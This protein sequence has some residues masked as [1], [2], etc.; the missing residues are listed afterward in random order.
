MAMRKVPAILL[1][2]LVAT[3]CASTPTDPEDFE[4]G[5]VVPAGKEDDFFSLSASEFVVEGRSTVTVEDGAGADRAKELIGLKHIS[6]AW[7]LNQ[8]LVDKEEDEANHAYGGL[9]AMVKSG[10]YQDLDI[11][12]LDATTY[13]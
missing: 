9:G 4:D 2:T 13:E 6:I 1:A 8:Y 12:Q 10:S 5:F 7:F 11:V 3:G